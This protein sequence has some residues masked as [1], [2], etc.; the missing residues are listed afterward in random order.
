MAKTYSIGFTLGARLGGSFNRVMGGAA[1]KFNTLG[2]EIKNLSKQRGLIERVEQDQ[3]ALEKSRLA[4]SAASRE[5]NRLKLALRK[6]PGNAGL[7]KDLQHAQQ[8]AEKLSASLEKQKARLRQDELALDRAGISV[9]E[10]GGAYNRLGQSMDRARLKHDRLERAFSRKSAAAERLRKMR[11]QILGMAG[12]IYG[13]VRTVGQAA[14]FETAGVRLSTV[15]PQN[16]WRKDLSLSKTHALD[17]SRHNLA[18]PTDLMNSEYAL[19][20]AGLDA[21][22]SRI[23]SEIVSK[24]AKVTSGAAEGVGEVMATVFNNLG[25]QLEGNASKRLERIGELLTKAQFKFQIRDFNQLGDSMKYAAPALAQ[26][27]VE[28]SQGVT[29][30]GELN[31]A[32]L[33]GS[34]AGTSLAAS[35][36][37]LS[38]A[39]QQFGFDI[40]RDA[41]GSLDFIQT[42]QNM[43]DAIGGFDNMDQATIDAMQKAFGDDG[44][45]AVVLLGQKLEELKA[46]QKDVAKSSK[47]LVD[48]SYQRFLDSTSGRLT[49]FANNVR[50]LGI[51][52]A[53]TLLPGINSVLKPLT[54]M[55]GWVGQLIQKY[56]VIGQMLGGA[57][58]GLGLVVTGMAAAAA[59]TWAWNAAFAANPIGI[60]VAAA[61]AAAALIVHYWK[62]ISGFFISLWKGIKKVFAEGVK[63]LTAVFEHSPIGLLF[64]AGKF[65]L[66]LLGELFGTNKNQAAPLGTAY[67][68]GA[69]SSAAQA[70]RIPEANMVHQAATMNVA[71]TI[72]VAAGA[73][74]G[75]VKAAVEAG[76]GESERRFGQ[77]LDRHMLNQQRLAF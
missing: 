42:L 23:G 53:N 51:T 77:M 9:R 69:S 54:A 47:G 35:F 7:A 49:I 75:Q 64:K 3:A 73:D 4:L 55:V 76:M 17:F 32:G 46:A 5:V 34:L 52:F 28:L 63:F 20:S 10:L 25:S 59:A 40:A 70:A 13:A 43:S 24:V 68:A 6:D 14:R 65:G 8:R 19:N 27:N 36:R 38:K 74:Y 41:N 1:Y 62:P 39:S 56:P 18:A 71:P 16:A 57:A 48:R 26:Y 50:I 61:G 66:K 31:S 67:A 44:Q 45:R 2:K 58:T 11:G 12:A 21:A 60:V 15:L 33:Q 72:N 22:T 29:L 37:Q 30:I